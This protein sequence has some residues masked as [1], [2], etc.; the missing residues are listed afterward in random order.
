[1]W[2]NIEDYSQIQY[3]PGVQKEMFFAVGSSHMFQRNH[4]R[5]QKFSAIY[6][7]EYIYL[8]N[9]SSIFLQRS[10]HQSITEILY[11]LNWNTIFRKLYSTPYKQ[12]FS[13]TWT[14]SNI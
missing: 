10:L 3:R 5:Q 9:L 13:E 1:M 8:S 14:F 11:Y 6:C 12:D 2:V 7:L 4:G